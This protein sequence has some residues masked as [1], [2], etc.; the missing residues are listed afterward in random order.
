MSKMVTPE[1]QVMPQ[2]REPVT[3]RKSKAAMKEYPKDNDEYGLE[4]EAIEPETSSQ[5]QEDNDQDEY[6]VNQD[7][8][9][10]EGNLK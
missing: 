10:T 3:P 8:D 7:M 2:T 9:E 1:A 4:S 5:D 6:N